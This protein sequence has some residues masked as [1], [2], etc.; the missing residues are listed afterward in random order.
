MKAKKKNKTGS[1]I[2]NE[3]ALEEKKIM[4]KQFERKNSYR[5]YVLDILIEHFEEEIRK[6][7]E[8]VKVKANPLKDVENAMEVLKGGK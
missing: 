8:W 1:V 6:E 5:S 3:K 4:Q 7:N 2:D